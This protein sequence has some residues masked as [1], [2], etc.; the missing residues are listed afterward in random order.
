[1]SFEIACDISDDMRHAL[2]FN[3]DM[4]LVQDFVRANDI[5]VIYRR[6]NIHLENEVKRLREKVRKAQEI[7]C[8]R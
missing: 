1:M 3:R 5:A 2:N 7:L 8:E 4:P 6:A